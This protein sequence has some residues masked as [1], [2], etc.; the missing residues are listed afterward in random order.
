MSRRTLI[1][2]PIAI[3]EVTALGEGFGADQST[4]PIGAGL[5]PV[6]AWYPPFQFEFRDSSGDTRGG[7][8]RRSRTRTVAR[9]KAPDF[10]RSAANPCEYRNRVRRNA[11]R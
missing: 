5:Q 4:R 7:Y 11:R 10:D 3:V 1:A 6:P 8:H 2:L 9:P